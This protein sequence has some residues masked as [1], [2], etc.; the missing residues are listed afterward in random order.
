[1]NKLIVAVCFYWP[2]VSSCLNIQNLISKFISPDVAQIFAY[3]NLLL[4]IA[5]VFL[6]RKHVKLL[7]KTNR[8]WLV[9]YVLYYLFGIL[10]TGISGFQTSIIATFVPVIY[11]AGF[12]VL[13]SNPDQYKVFF[14]VITISLIISS[15]VTIIFHKLNFNFTLG[16]IYSRDLDRAEGLYGD[17]NNA[18][19][20]SIIAYI[21]F[22]KLFKP[23]KLIFKGLKII[24]LSL[25]FYSLFITF[26]TT[27]LFVFAI[28]FFL[29]NYQFF[30]GIKLILLG[31]AI[32]MFYIGIFNIKNQTDNLD[33][34]SAQIAKVDNII[35]VLT[36]NLDK[37]DNS[38]RG[39]L[40]ENILF[41]LYEN[42]LIGN[43]I[44]FS[45]YMRGHNT[46]IGIWVDAGIITFVFFLFVLFY[47]FIKTFSLELNLRFF[48]ISILFTLYI[49]MISLQS[50]IN[51]P[52]L[53]VLFVFV[54]YLIDY[55]NTNQN[56]ISFFLKKKI[57]Y[58]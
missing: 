45:V 56:Y 13:L 35:N 11:F 47:Y 18:A 50:V 5:G 51:Q 32:I 9:F 41:Y 43:G 1:M 30:T 37:I 42:P 33:L 26:S 31:V 2:L 14:K 20:A 57:T 3:S 15:I 29:T 55:A 12:Y 46:Y 4:I 40:I 44:D 8:L 27:G 58:D 22:D 23:S 7:S 25:I 17:A 38:G 34:S 24:I 21:L 39:D 53:V 10:A 54:G 16:E 28:I 19:L 6:F 48:A 49:F 52:Y 36:L